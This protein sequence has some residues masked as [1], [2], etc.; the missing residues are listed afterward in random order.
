MKNHTATGIASLV[1][2][3]ATYVLYFVLLFAE[4]NWTQGIV[5]GLL[6]SLASIIVG[7][8]ARFG[9]AKDNFGVAGFALGMIGFVLML[10]DL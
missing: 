6:L 9:K 2:G 7:L 4:H 5:T 10:I 8:V 1:L 3:I